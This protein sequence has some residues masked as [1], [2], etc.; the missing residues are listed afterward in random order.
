MCL[1]IVFGLGKFVTSTEGWRKDICIQLKSNAICSHQVC[2]LYDALN[3]VIKDISFETKYSRID[4]GI[5]FMEYSLSKIWSD[6][7]HYILAT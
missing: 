4:W 5:K 3:I 2:F 1:F 7:I 6:M